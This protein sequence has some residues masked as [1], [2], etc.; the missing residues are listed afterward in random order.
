MLVQKKTFD[1]FKNSTFC[2]ARHSMRL[3]GLLE[4]FLSLSEPR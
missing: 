1:F 4:Y 2:K 3:L